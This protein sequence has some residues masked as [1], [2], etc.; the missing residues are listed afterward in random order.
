ML[1]A[2]NLNPKPKSLKSYLRLRDQKHIW[3]APCALALG[4]HIFRPRNANLQ[5]Y[6][7]GKASL[8]RD[9]GELLKS[10]VY[11]FIK[12]KRAGQQ[13]GSGMNGLG[14]ASFGIDRNIIA[15]LLEKKKISSIESA[16]IRN[17]LFPEPVSA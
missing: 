4:G 15:G 16:A 10:D 11:P 9:I 12:H 6:M 5:N 8:M 3:E 17:C 1:T 14:T 2:L 7:A 13:I